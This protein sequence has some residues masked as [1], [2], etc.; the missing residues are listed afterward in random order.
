METTYASGSM[1]AIQL[2]LLQ[3][4]TNILLNPETAARELLGIARRKVR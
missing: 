3:V 1:G 2:A 4:G